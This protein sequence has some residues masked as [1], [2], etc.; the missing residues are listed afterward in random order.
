M[1]NGTKRK[2]RRWI[3]AVALSA[4]VGACVVYWPN[5]MAADK[6][7]SGVQTS[8][9]HLLV[10][11]TVTGADGKPVTGLSPFDFQIADNGRPEKLLAMQT[12]GLAL[13][14]SKT[15]AEMVIVLDAVNCTWEKMQL[16]RQ[17]VEEFLRRRGGRLPVPTRIVMLTDT[18]MTIPPHATED[19]NALAQYIQRTP[20]PVHSL[21]FQAGYYGEMDRAMWSMDQM[22]KLARFESAQPG[23]KLV[24][25]ISHGWHPLS[26]DYLAMSKEDL[27]RDFELDETLTDNLLMAR[28]T[29]DSIDPI[30]D[31]PGENLDYY[32]A[33][34]KPVKKYEQ[35]DT[36]DLMLQV[37]ARHT[38]GLVLNQSTDIQG[39]IEQAMGTLKSWYTLVYSPTKT[40][41]PN[42]F[43]AIS[44]SL[45][46]TP[47]AVV[48]A[49]IGYYANPH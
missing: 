5:A 6:A 14:G 31:L 49:P 7:T 27:Q 37:L 8:T 13:S 35:V 30:L 21:R 10:D 3:G 28:I 22:N 34:V 1:K 33:F 41:D 11:V 25:W 40:S 12:G 47:G 43:H 17:D 2:M 9:G 44:V 19:G 32:Q 36:P 29:L 16:E 42:A 46:N 24:V 4:T 15:P 45:S 26:R 23:R 48:H 18:Q 38:G 20:N 39:E